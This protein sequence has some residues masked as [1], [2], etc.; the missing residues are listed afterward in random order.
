[1]LQP[2]IVEPG[3]TYEYGCYI[4]GKNINNVWMSATNF[5]NRMMF[6]QNATDWTELKYEY[7]AD[8]SGMVNLRLT[9]EGI[10]DSLY[11]DDFFV[12]EKGSD[13]NLLKNSDFD[14]E[15]ENDEYMGNVG[16]L[17]Y[18]M[19]TVRNAE[20]NNVAISLLLAPHYFLDWVLQRYPETQARTCLLYTSDA[21]DD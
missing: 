16:G 9:S 3:K 6:P 20:K 14:A 2:V 4:K 12:R 11:I 5:D 13:V 1:M 7:T 19:N 17:A 8:N 15:G 21:A 10:V 18:F